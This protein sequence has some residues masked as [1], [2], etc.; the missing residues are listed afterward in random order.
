MTLVRVGD[1][2]VGWREAGTITATA[3]LA[4]ASEELV[5]EE[6]DYES[7]E[8]LRALFASVVASATDATR[9]VGTAPVLGECGFAPD[10]DRF[11]REI[12]V[13]PVRSE[14][15]VTLNE[16]EAA[17][18]AS[19]SAETSDLPDRWTSANPAFQQCDVT[20]RVVRDYLGGE[21][22]VAGVVRDGRRV[23]R[24]AWNRLPSGLEV[25]LSREQFVAGEEFEAAEVLGEF[26]G[27]T[28]DERYALLAERVREKLR[29]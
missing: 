16:L 6:V 20:A 19:W 3:R 9:V 22:L 5:V 2:R 25:D 15:P 26:I 8:G 23:D 4:R 28:A 11:V 10:D 21:I 27:S 12:T 1:H 17:I 13:V 14:R 7:L 24:H 29:A 18:R